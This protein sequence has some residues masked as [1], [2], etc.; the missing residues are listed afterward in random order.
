VKTV[1][2]PFSRVCGY[3]PPCAARGNP[4][5]TKL[6]RLSHANLERSTFKHN[7]LER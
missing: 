7:P 3:N 6:E 4:T 2:T 1:Q 5:R